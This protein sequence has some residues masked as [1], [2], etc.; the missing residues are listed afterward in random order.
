MEARVNKKNK[1]MKSFIRIIM[2]ATLMGVMSCDYL[3]VVP[4][5]TA[6]LEHTFSNRSVMDK[7]MRTVYS[8]LPDP[9]NPHYYPAYFTSRDEFDWRTDVRVGNL[10]AGQISQG[11]QNSNSPYLDYWS[12]RNG[13]KP[14]YE[15]IRTCNIFL[16]NAHIPKD[17]DETERQKWI[18]EVKFL[19]AYYHFFLMQL[20]GPI[21]VVRENLPLS[22]SPDEVMT[23]R[24][25]IDDV[26]AYIVELLDEAIPDLPPVIQDPNTEQGRISQVIALGIK[27]KVL[28]WAASPLFNGNPDYAGWVDNRGVQLIPATYDPTKWAIAAEA[29]KEA[30][31][32]AHANGFQ[33]YEFNKFSTPQTFAMNDTL[34]T[35]MT[36]RKAVTEDIERNT[37]VIWA[38]QEQFANGKGGV[39]SALPQ[40]GNMVRSLF[41][42]LYVTDQPLYFNYMSASWHMGELFYTDNGVPM[43]EDKYFDYDNRYRP[44][45]ATPGDHHESYIAT[46]QVTA[47]MHFH[48]EPRFYANLVIDRGFFEL[49]STTEDG[50]RSFSP[51]VQS[52]GNEIVGTQGQASYTPKKILAFE[53]SGSQ[54]VTGRGYTQHNYHFP[55][56]RLSDLYLLYAEALNETKAQPDNEVYYWVDQI[57][58]KAGLKGVVDSWREAAYNPDAP[59]N[60]NDM[61]RIIQKE[62]LIE[63]AF[64]GQRFWDVRRW[65]IAG[66]YWSLSPTRWGDIGASSDEA[67]Y[68]PTAYAPKRQVTF[69]D[70][71]FPISID[72]LR[73]N[74][75]LVQTYGW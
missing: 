66:Q 65:K 1:K 28:A 30:I 64:E 71:L 51:F 10:P 27:A 22:A 52:R 49:A 6:T 43:E 37:G 50:G 74:N 42:N 16:E 72:D 44:R 15:A 23:Y 9:T 48:R 47:G 18:A 58:E 62:R 56:L 40:L 36:V 69:R 70:Y 19:K 24:E 55:L 31:D 45:R 25:P 14:M 29:I 68:I 5:D 46:N 12:G 20:Y 7:F 61:R 4:N 73:V 41:P 35:M 26:V 63:L 13:G 39:P 57:R 11:N 67:F 33:L 21:V 75:N 34:V 2:L 59:R 54:G 53:S 60:K 17:I 32:V 8:Y 3:D 38:T